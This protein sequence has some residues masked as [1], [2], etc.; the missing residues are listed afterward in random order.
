VIAEDSE[1]K[2]SASTISVTVFV[3][4]IICHFIWAHFDKDYGVYLGHLSAREQAAAQGRLERAPSSRSHPGLIV[5]QRLALP[6]E[7]TS[8]GG[9]RGGKI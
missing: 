1:F 2:P 4:S 3:T 8:A 7:P 5:R 9:M 6:N